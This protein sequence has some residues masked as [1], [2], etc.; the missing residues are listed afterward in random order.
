MVAEGSLIAEKF[1]NGSTQPK[2]VFSYKDGDYFGEIALIQNTVRQ[3]SIRT[4]TSCKILWIDRNTFK[5]LLGPVEEIL[6]RNMEKY[7]KY[8]GQ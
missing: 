4:M 2:T 5:R 7:K 6:S 8:L 1:E 3:A